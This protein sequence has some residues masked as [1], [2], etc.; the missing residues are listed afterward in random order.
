ME[1]AGFSE[2]LANASLILSVTLPRIILLPQYNLFTYT[3]NI[4]I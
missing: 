2:M 4:T 3:A 1:A